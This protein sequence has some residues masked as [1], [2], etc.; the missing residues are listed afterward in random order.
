MLLSNTLFSYK[1]ELI[2]ESSWLYVEYYIILIDYISYD[3]Y[4][5]QDVY[6]NY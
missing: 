2:S 6:G 5:V 4:S 1:L 3:Y